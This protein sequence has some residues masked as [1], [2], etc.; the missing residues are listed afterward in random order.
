[1]AITKYTYDVT[2]DFPGGAVNVSTL[3]TEIGTS[4]IVT[5]IERIDTVDGTYANG[6]LTGGTIN[7]WFKATLS[8]GD[9]T[10]L[11][12]DTTGPAG[13][14]IAAHNNAIVEP[15]Q[16]VEVTNTP[17]VSVTSEVKTTVW[18]PHQSEYSR[19]YMFSCDFT[20]KQTWYEGST[21]IT[22]QFAADSVKTEFDLAHG[23]G[24]GGAVVC[25]NRGLVTE[26]ELLAPPSGSAG[27]FVAVVDI[28]AIPQTEREFGEATGGTYEID[29]VAGKLKFY[30]APPNGSNVNITYYASPSGHGP[31]IVA[32]PPSGKMW[33]INSAEVQLSA[34]VDMTDSLLQNLIADVPV[35]DGSGNYVTTLIDHKLAPDAVYSNVGNFLDYTY[36]S[37]PIIPAFGGTRGLSKDTIILRWDYTAA[38]ELMSSINMRMKVWTKHARGFGGE[39]ATVTIYGVEHDE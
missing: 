5:A 36:G 13:G 22:E 35:F 3:R 24:N 31:S 20:K 2:N 7:I 19:I 1:M 28:D 32:G 27:G 15:T 17:A 18:K 14:L 34:D 4:A 37:Y 21:K 26:E 10:L 30:T 33:I 9:K 29:Y 38:M 11:D 6:V 25:L 39:R 16:Q 8:T 12:A 23:S